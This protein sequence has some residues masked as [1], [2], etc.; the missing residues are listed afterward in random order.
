MKLIAKMRVGKSMPITQDDG[1][2]VNEI[3]YGP[4]TLDA[5]DNA[6]WHA[7]IEGNQSLSDILWRTAM[8]N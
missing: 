7:Y 5:S 6:A 3:R 1:G 8:Q 2:V 4:E